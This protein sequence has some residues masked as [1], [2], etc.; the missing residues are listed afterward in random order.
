MATHRHRQSA[1]PWAKV[2][3]IVVGIH[4][5]I[6]G[7]LLWLART[8]SG[9]DFAKVYDIKLFQPEKP[10]EPE[11]PETPPPPPPPMEKPLEAPPVAAAAVAAPAPAAA[12]PAVGG[13]AVGGL[14]W[15]GGRFV[16]GFEDG[17][18]GAFHASVTSRFRDAY[19]EPAKSEQFGPAKV[20]LT[21]DANGGVRSY[22]LAQSSGSSVN[23]QALL[24]AAEV[25]KQR[26]VGAPPD[27][28]AR[29]VSV[30]FVPY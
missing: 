3:A 25:V 6:G 17:P 18:L 21:V 14:N 13:S 12:G 20:E 2:F 27:S 23:D 24:A 5:L 1:F 30:N 7:G 4:A 28:K 15:G 29:V 11:K 19:H 9:Q 26:G 22:R 16:G 10:P 8:Q